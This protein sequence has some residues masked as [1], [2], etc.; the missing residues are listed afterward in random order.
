MRKAAPS[1][2]ANGRIVLP[3]VSTILLLTVIGTASA[4]SRRHPGPVFIV[5]LFV[6]IA[7]VTGIAVLLFGPRDLWMRH[8]W[9]LEL[10]HPYVVALDS[11]IALAWGGALCLASGIRMAADGSNHGFG[12]RSR[13]IWGL[14]ITIGIVGCLAIAVLVMGLLVAAK[15]S[16][17]EIAYRRFAWLPVTALLLQL[18]LAKPVLSHLSYFAI[19]PPLLTCLVSLFLAVIGATLLASA[20]ERNEPSSGLLQATVVAAIPGMLLFAYLTYALVAALVFRPGAYW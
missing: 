18:L 12:R 1:G 7:G 20:R 6:V 3:F 9:L 14:V 16:T 4:A 13:P 8:P 5:A 17:I 19:V 15:V 2:K 10:L 11:V